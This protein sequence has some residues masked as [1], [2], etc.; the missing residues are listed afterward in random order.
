MTEAEFNDRYMTHLGEV[1]AIS[2]YVRATRY[3]SFPELTSLEQRYLTIYELDVRDQR[4][5]EETAEEHRRRVIDGEMCR[6]PDD[7]SVVRTMYYVEQSPR[8]LAAGVTDRTPAGVFLAFA[9]PTSPE[10]DGELN[11][12]YDNVHLADVLDLPGF[13]AAQRYTSTGL[14][15][16]G[17]PWITEAPYLAVYEH[18]HPNAAAY[19]AA[20]AKFG[21]GIAAGL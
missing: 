19:G 3:R 16:A 8:R 5:L 6:P 12:W 13:T 18:T 11:D 21:E 2:G 14:D 1:L 4:H 7:D 15:L 9:A 17:E 20:F 10:C